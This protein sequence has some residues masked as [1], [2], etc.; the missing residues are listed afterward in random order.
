MSEK[1]NPWKP[2]ML[3]DTGEV[4]DP[5]KAM[6]QKVEEIKKEFKMMDNETLEEFETRR[7]ATID[8]LEKEI[9]RR[10]EQKQWKRMLFK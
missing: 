6:I 5:I 1:D 7:R 8:S 3:M 4:V 10:I 2:I 9:S